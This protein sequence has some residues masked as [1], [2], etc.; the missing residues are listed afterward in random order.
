MS[1]ISLDDQNI[2]GEIIPEY[3]SVK[4]AVFPFVK[5][6]GVNTLLGPEMKSTGEVMGVGNSFGEAY[7]KSQQGAGAMI[8]QMGNALFSVRDDDKPV[9]I[10]LARYL[11]QSGFKIYATAGTA[12]NS[13]RT[14]Q[15][16]RNGFI[17]KTLLQWVLERR[18]RKR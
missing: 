11:S 9:A 16:W 3:Y 2:H 12:S 5:F 17:A 15:R 8:P 13:S 4:E 14:N 18:L 7:N 10:E 6:P 1:G